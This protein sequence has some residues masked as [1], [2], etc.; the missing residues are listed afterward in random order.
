MFPLSDLIF[1]N[2]V[3]PVVHFS[4]KLDTAHLIFERL[5]PMTDSVLN[6]AASEDAP[7]HAASDDAPHHPASG[8]APSHVASD[9]AVGKPLRPLRRANEDGISAAVKRTWPKIEV[10]LDPTLAETVT[11][12][13]KKHG[14]TRQEYLL[15]A[16]HRQ[17]A[18]EN[19]DYDL[20]TMEQYRLN[21]VVD[22]YTELAVRITNLQTAVTTGLDQ[23][24]GLARGSNYLLNEEDGELE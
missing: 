12:W 18:W 9:D 22:G 3:F 1:S 17:I 4:A 20:P 5:S 23:I 8:D 16:I 13:A 2:T 15:D 10:R 24:V 7:G 6:Q 19:Q 21:Q 14:Q 11:Y